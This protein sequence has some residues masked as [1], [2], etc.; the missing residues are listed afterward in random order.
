MKPIAPSWIIEDLGRLRRGR[1]E[2]ERAGAEL[3]LPPPPSKDRREEQPVGGTVI[4]IEPWSPEPD[5][6]EAIAVNQLKP[7]TARA[8]PVDG[9]VEQQASTQSAPRRRRSNNVFSLEQ[10]GRH[11]F[12]C[13][14]ERPARRVSRSFDAT[15]LPGFVDATPLVLLRED[16]QARR[17]STRR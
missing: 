4:V 12:S 7:V 13:V 10:Q 6:G 8:C 5:G 15:T 17:S 16:L 3:P 2:R 11:H 14:L 1:A 9:S